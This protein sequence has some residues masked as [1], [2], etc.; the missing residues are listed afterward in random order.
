MENNQMKQFALLL[1][2]LFIGAAFV[3]GSSSYAMTDSGNA[4]DTLRTADSASVKKAPSNVKED[5][6]VGPIKSVMLGPIDKKLVEEGK[7]QFE[8]K[9]MSCHRLDSRLVGPALGDVTNK[10]SPEFIMNMI[11]NSSEMT[12]KDSIARKLLDEY[13]IPMV[14]PGISKQEARAVLEYLRSKAADKK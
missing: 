11:L 3:M 2:V 10:R 13:H 12:E 5:K 7:S 4:G 9:C 6:G 1:S 14:V 8:Q